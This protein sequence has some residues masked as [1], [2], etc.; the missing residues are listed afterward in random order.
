MVICNLLLISIISYDK[1]CLIVITG[2]RRQKKNR[3]S[4]KENGYN[5]I[6]QKK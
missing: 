2:K 4:V 1:N 5:R 3:Q 6:W